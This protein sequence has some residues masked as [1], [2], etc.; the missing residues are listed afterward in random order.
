ML[1]FLITSCYSEKKGSPRL[2]LDRLEGM[3]IEGGVSTDANDVAV[4]SVPINELESSFAKASET[5]KKRSYIE[6]KTPDNTII[7]EV[8]DL[9]LFENNLVI[10]DSRITKKVFLFDTLGNYKFEVGKRGSGPG[11]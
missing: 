2:N 5:F 7:G 3:K 8:S 9:K 1:A 6:L 4:V 11:E 10:L